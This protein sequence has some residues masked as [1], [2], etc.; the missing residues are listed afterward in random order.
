M[1]E[2]INFEQILS[3]V[4][5]EQ[6][7]QDLQEID[8]NLYKNALILLKTKE[9]QIKSKETQQSLTTTNVELEKQKR[10]VKHIRKQLN[11]L[12]D[13]RQKKIINSA[14]MRAKLP[15][16]IINNDLLTPE[17][18]EFFDNT[19]KLF[20]SFKKDLLNK[21]ISPEEIKNTQTKENTTKTIETKENMTVK[22]LVDMPKFYGPKKQILGPY[23]KEQIAEVPTLIAKAL[24]KK[25][26]AT[27]KN[28]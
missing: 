27:A 22:F 10:L 17:E 3:L 2:Q 19:V 16:T 13:L 1:S 5:R 4:R 14:R 6:T 18:K 28:E 23:K 26:R 7:R 15:S 24:I 9:K 20:R 21:E 8:K 11:D 12:I 25:G